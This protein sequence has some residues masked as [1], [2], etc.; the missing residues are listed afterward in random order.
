[1]LCRT[2]TRPLG[3][4]LVALVL[5][6]PQAHTAPT[7]PLAAVTHPL[8]P[9]AQIADTYG[10]MPCMV[11]TVAIMGAATTFIG[12]LPTFEQAGLVGPVLMALLRMVQGLAIGER[13]PCRGRPGQRIARR[14]FVA[15]PVPRHRALTREV[16]STQSSRRNATPPPLPPP[17]GEFGCALCYLVETAPHAKRGLSGGKGFAGSM[18]GM[19][20]GVILVMIIIAACNPAQL[21]LYGWRC[22][23]RSG[24][25]QGSDPC[26]GG[27]LEAL[28]KAAAQKAAAVAAARAE[29]A[30]QAVAPSCKCPHPSNAS[31]PGACAP[32]G[33]VPFLL[34]PISGG[35][36]V[37]LRLTMEEPHE[38]VAARAAAHEATAASRQELGDTYTPPG[39]W[40]A[41]S[42]SPCVEML[43][44]SWARVLLQFL[45]EASL[46]VSF[47]LALTYLPGYFQDSYGMPQE[48]ALG[49]V[50]RSL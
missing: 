10:R 40:Q 3:Q 24:M 32:P 27:P 38:F 14:I 13:L 50:R 6:S 2:T 22:V 25:G 36:A 47:W 7:T 26:R 16:L 41:V 15:S 43:R 11:A 5:V 23:A 46:S 20:F 49:M 4:C 39:C 33:R 19:G 35:A 34:A 48:M 37:Y 21:A 1:M 42:A 12:C 45:F 28:R 8:T 9:F 44:H 18:G 31:A 29:H 30:Q 17:G